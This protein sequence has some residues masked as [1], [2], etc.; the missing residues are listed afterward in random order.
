LGSGD[1][2]EAAAAIAGLILGQ[3]LVDPAKEDDPADED[4]EERR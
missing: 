3:D 1:C 2:G 4:E